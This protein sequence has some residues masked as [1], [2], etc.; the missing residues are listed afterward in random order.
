MGKREWEG[1]GGGSEGGGGGGREKA[2]CDVLAD[3]CGPC[4]SF[5]AELSE[6]LSEEHA[7]LGQFR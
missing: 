6:A 2:R 3:I 1:R 5:A 4:T 7:L